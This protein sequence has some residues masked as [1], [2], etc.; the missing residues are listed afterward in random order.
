MTEMMNHNLPI[1]LYNNTNQYPQ[2]FLEL[3]S[4][5][6]EFILDCGSGDRRLDYDKLINLDINPLK[7]VDII[8][9]SY[10]LPFKDN[11]FGLIL[12]QATLEHCRHPFI[13]AD[14]LYRV[15]KKDGLIYA[16]A[17]FMQPFHAAPYH[18]FNMTL[19][20]IEELFRKFIKIESG[21][22]GGLSDTVPWMVRSTSAS[23]N[24]FLL[25]ILIKL[26]RILD[27]SV[28]PDELKNIAADV[29]FYGRKT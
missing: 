15:S 19:L 5:T 11:S 29:Y 16:E 28:K 22:F 13:A 25:S 10:K 18:F 3:V 12:S 4:N 20:G 23:R 21:A 2:K 9:D 27:N 1:I 8:G 17:A 24:K 26:I 14:E 7:G 6:K